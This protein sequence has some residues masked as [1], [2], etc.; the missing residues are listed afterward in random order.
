MQHLCSPNLI[1]IN[2][3]SYPNLLIWRRIEAG[4][5]LNGGSDVHVHTAKVG[6][7]TLML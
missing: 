4:Q 5:V 7:I 1:F 2:V 3:K 6:L